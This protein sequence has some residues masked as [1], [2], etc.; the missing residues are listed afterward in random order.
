M[1][2]PISYNSKSFTLHFPAFSFISSQLFDCY[3]KKKTCHL[4]ETSY[5]PAWVEAVV[6]CSICLVV[7]RLAG[8]GKRRHNTGDAGVA[9]QQKAHVTHELCHTGSRRAKSCI[10]DNLPENHLHP[11]MC[12][13]TCAHTNTHTHARAHAHTGARA[14]TTHTAHNAHDTTQHT[15]KHPSLCVY[16]LCHRRPWT[17]E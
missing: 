16:A 10:Y 9:P 4:P 14:H 12:A 7:V 2:N 8:V 6:Q 1:S 3:Q 11:Q 5:G 15:H 13:F 17:R